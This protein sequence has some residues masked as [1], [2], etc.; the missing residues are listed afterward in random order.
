MYIGSGGHVLGYGDG[1][2][3]DRRRPHTTAA[4]SDHRDESGGAANVEN[5]LMEIEESGLDR[6]EMSHSDNSDSGSDEDDHNQLGNRNHPFLPPVPMGVGNPPPGAGQRG[7]VP[8]GLPQFDRRARRWGGD[9][10]DEMFEGEGHRLGGKEVT[11]IVGD[12]QIGDYNTHASG[13]SYTT[14]LTLFLLPFFLPSSFLLSFIPHD[15]FLCVTTPTC[16]PSSCYKASHQHI[17]SGHAHPLPHS[18]PF[19]GDPLHQIPRVID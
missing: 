2:V 4:T 7:R 13:E 12:L 14:S 17:S 6:E 9:D 3:S 15:H 16:S 8:W 1:S 18:R 11:P 5:E 19:L 10:D